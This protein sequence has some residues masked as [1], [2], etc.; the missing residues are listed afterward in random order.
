MIH[1]DVVYLAHEGARLENTKT[2][3][4][5]EIYAGTDSVTYTAIRCGPAHSTLYR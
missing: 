5:L 2:Q 1:F 3:K 4:W